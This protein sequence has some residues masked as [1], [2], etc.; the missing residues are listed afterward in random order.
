MK[1][2]INTDNGNPN[3]G[4][5]IPEIK[6]L[7]IESIIVKYHPRQDIGN[8]ETL[9]HSINKLGLQEPL[10]VYP[11]GEDQYA[12]IDGQRRLAA[13]R[14]LRMSEVPCIIKEVDD[15]TAA[16]LSYVINS[17]RN[18][19]SPIEDAM[20]LRYMQ[21]QYG[22]TMEELYVKGHGTPALIAQKMKLLNLPASVQQMI[23]GGELTAAHGRELLRLPT[24]GEQEKMAKS[25]RKMS[26]VHLRHQR[27]SRRRYLPELK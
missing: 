17:E 21:E 20:H 11:I 18:A 7:G 26:N 23:T 2:P 24:S 8:I 3:N 10:T 6:M 22:F 1:E 25:P 15:A 13:C 16:G 14:K 9:T 4:N 12:I 5:G 27:W 19:L